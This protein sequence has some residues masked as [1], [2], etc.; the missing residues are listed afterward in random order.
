[1]T[2]H[3]ASITLHRLSAVIH[4]SVE[5]HKTESS[6]HE[7]I[8]FLNSYIGSLEKA[9]GDKLATQEHM[10]HLLSFGGSIEAYRAFECVQEI[11]TI[12]LKNRTFTLKELESLHE[13]MRTLRV[14]TLDSVD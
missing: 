5:D 12:V 2:I 11:A 7:D 4:Q 8:A 13:N 6:A 9:L 10:K 1:M 14:F 3:D